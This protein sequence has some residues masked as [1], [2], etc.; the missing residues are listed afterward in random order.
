MAW[1]AER[2]GRKE[3]GREGVSECVCERGEDGGREGGR[4][5]KARKREGQQH[6]KEAIA[7][8]ETMTGKQVSR[9]YSLLSKTTTGE[10]E[11]KKET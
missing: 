7:L 9:M 6:V 5:E 3:G 1:D 8:T 10:Q 2:E 11:R 4:R